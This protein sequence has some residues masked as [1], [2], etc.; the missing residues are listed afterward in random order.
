MV[1]F[2]FILI[3]LLTHSFNPTKSAYCEKTQYAQIISSGEFLYRYDIYDTH[4]DN[5]ICLLESTYFVEIVGETHDSYR[6]NYNGIGGYV[7]HTAVRKVNGTPTTPYPDNI[8]I[9]TYNKNC[10][11]RHTPESNDDNKISIL[12]ANC[13]S[14][15]YIGKTIGET[16]EDFGKDTWYYVEYLNVKGYIYSSYVSSISS[17]FPNGEKLSFIEDTPKIINPLTNTQCTIIVICLT[18]PTL[19]ILYLMFRK[20]RK[21]RLPRKQ[22]VDI[23]DDIL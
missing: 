17:V 5:L 9:L 10:Y 6:V 1:K 14:L 2:L 16:V 23:D 8:R 7:K 11:L 18:L 22:S 21:K 19:L 4:Y 20:P 13:D 15:K 12:P 3:L